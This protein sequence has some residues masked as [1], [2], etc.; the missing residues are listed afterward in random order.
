MDKKSIKN[1]VLVVIFVVLAPLI[2]VGLTALG[3]TIGI[4]GNPSSNATQT[5]EKAAKVPEETKSTTNNDI[6]KADDKKI[7]NSTSS[8]N[9]D[10]N[11]NSG[12]VSSTP[13]AGQS[14]V[15]KTGDTLFTIAS[16]AYGEGNAQ[17]GIDKIK[18]ANNMNNN[19]LTVGK[20]GASA[21]RIGT[22][23]LITVATEAVKEKI[24]SD[25]DSSSEKFVKGVAVDLERDMAI[26]AITEGKKLIRI[27]L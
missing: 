9:K 5:T 26:K 23:S 22:G 13:I 27:W 20:L 1:S 19:N 12:T 15:V 8:N 14:Y 3:N 25:S 10:K 6:P 18:Q 24:I 16:S 21:K 4:K 2:L 17:S 7:S 11:Q